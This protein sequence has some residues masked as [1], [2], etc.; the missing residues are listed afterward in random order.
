MQNSYKSIP[1]YCGVVAEEAAILPLAEKGHA[2]ARHD[3]EA[4][5]N[6]PTRHFEADTPTFDRWENAVVPSMQL[7]MKVENIH[8]KGSSMSKCGSFTVVVNT[9]FM[10]SALSSFSWSEVRV[11]VLSPMNGTRQY[12]WVWRIYTKGTTNHRNIKIYIAPSNTLPTKQQIKISGDFH[13]VFIPFK[14]DENIPPLRLTEPFDIVSS[15]TDSSL[16]NS[17]EECFFK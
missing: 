5:A 9:L 6:I 16:S 8:P 4:K 11:G 7:T 2:I 17:I 10:T 15:S 1:M 14:R 3:T 12:Q 13:T